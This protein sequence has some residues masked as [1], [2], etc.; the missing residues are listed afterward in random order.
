MKL[1][2]FLKILAKIG[3]GNVNKFNSRKQAHN[4]FELVENL[5]IPASSLETEFRGEFSRRVRIP[6]RHRNQIR[7]Q[8]RPFSLPPYPP[9]RRQ[10][11]QLHHWR[12]RLEQRRRRH[13]WA[14]S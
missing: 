10:L 8:N 7:R 3:P 5:L 4:R 6:Y 1:F 13:P 9:R 12:R 2:K 11:E 14:Q